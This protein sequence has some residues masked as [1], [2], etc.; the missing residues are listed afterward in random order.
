MQTVEKISITL[1]A[2]M[3]RIIRAEVEGGGYASNSEVIREAM[4]SWM[5][6]KRR[7][8]TF[9]AAIDR[10][11]ADA[12][13]GRVREFRPNPPVPAEAPGCARRQSDSMRVLWTHAAEA[14]LEE[15]SDY[16][17]A[18]NPE[19]AVSFVNEI[20]DAG[21]AIAD[22]PRAFALV[23]SLEHKG[24]RRRP[25][26]NYPIFYRAERD[27]VEILHVVRGSRD[28]VRVLFSDI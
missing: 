25:F 21:E 20:I 22:M 24:I 2:E 16:I 5:E 6:R 4:R 7:L 23:P 9:E 13:A 15:I 10:G 1:P 12:D 26:G 18:D 19:R 28:Y 8:A 11:L 14:D 3:V 27:A 17:K